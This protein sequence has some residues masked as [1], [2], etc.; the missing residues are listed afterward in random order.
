MAR[1]GRSLSG[2]RCT[3][4]ISASITPGTGL[5]P[6]VAPRFAPLANVAAFILTFLCVVVA[7]VFFRADNLP[8]AISLLSKMAD[9]TTTAFGRLE[10]AQAVF[11]AVYAAIAWFAPNT[12]TIMGYDHQNRTVG[13]VLRTWQMRP[14][15]I[16]A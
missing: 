13:Q 2:A 3:A 16:Y 8:A 12:Q 5:G 11:I 15:F 7:W 1:P 10:I 6:S 14:L 4:P 9:P